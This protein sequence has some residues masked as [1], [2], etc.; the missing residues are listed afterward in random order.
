MAMGSR[1]RREAENSIAACRPFRNRT[2]SLKGTRGSTR[3]LGWLERHAQAGEIRELLSR[4]VYVVWSYDTPI[5]F[6]SEDEDGDR[7]AYY[8]DD[9]HSVT[10]SHHQTI[11]RVGM[12]EY[13]TIGERPK[14]QRRPAVRESV[15]AA[16]V[17][18]SSLP[19]VSQEEMETRWESNFTEACTQALTEYSAY[20]PDPRYS[21]P[22]WVPS[23]NIAADREAE[24]RDVRR[25]ER[26][27]AERPWTP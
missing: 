27:S 2:G 18:A 3:D 11:A 1:N 14:R 6:V 19:P 15:R 20:R 23:R 24:A 7:T 21:N 25:V 26:E 13:E 4:A 9:Y 8:V 22:D 12:G 5:A 16:A 10:T 17:Q